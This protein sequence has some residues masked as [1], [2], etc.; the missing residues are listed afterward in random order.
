MM[1]RRFDKSCLTEFICLILTAVLFNAPLLEARAGVSGTPRS[2][3]KEEAQTPTV[4]ERILKFPPGTLVEV[5]LINKLKIRG[6]LGEVKDEGF[7]LTNAQGNKIAVSFS[8]VKSVKRAK[9]GKT[10]RI[11]GYVLL[12]AA[13]FVVIVI[14]GAVAGK[15]GGG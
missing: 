12:G 7:S 6:R 14:V 1:K 3:P 5:K 4:K 13:A 11:V 2:G 9:G 8:E 15:W 10:G